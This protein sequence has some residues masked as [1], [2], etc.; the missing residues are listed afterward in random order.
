[1]P[2]QLVHELAAYKDIAK[3]FSFYGP[4]AW[5]FGD[6]M[7]ISAETLRRKNKQYIAEAN[8]VVMSYLKSV[9]MISD[10]LTHHTS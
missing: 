5:V 10:I 3:D 8:A 7:P 1:M 6:E 2:K 4:D 9:Y